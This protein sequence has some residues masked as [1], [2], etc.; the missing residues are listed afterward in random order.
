MAFEVVNTSV[1]AGLVAGEQGYC[2][3]LRT[4]GVPEGLCAMLSR[5]SHFDPQMSGAHPAVGVRML[6]FAGSSW[7]LVT[8]VAPCGLDYSGRANRIAHHVLIPPSELEAVNPAAVLAHFHFL[9]SFQGT[10]RYSPD[11]PEVDLAAPAGGAWAAAGLAGWDRD[12]AGLLRDQPATKRLL[13]LPAETPLRPLLAE[14]LQHLDP[15]MRWRLGVASGL[16]A[17]SA[18]DEGVGLRVLAGG[19][20]AQAQV[21][22]LAPGEKLHDLRGR[23]GSTRGRKPMDS[24]VPASP[25]PQE[26]RWVN[27]EGGPTPA[28]QPTPSPTPG[29][30]TIEFDPVPEQGPLV[31]G[32][33]ERASRS[34]GI[35]LAVGVLGLA[36][37]SLVAFLLAQ[38]IRQGT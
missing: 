19:E 2:D 18:W 15:P 16:D 31:P 34:L 30:I 4:R 35:V 21:F 37:G 28:P 17:N 9:S 3:A 10:P 32:Q 8:Q 26:D 14:L 27:L 13:V 20:A 29:P 7:G 38:W 36:A 1:A 22:G 11:P 12:M 23:P 6:R 24:P 5:L 25:P 33:P